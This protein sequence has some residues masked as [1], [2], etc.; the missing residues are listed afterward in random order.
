M[1]EFRFLQDPAPDQLEEAVAWNH[2]ELFVL[3][4]QAA[5]GEVH[6]TEGLTWTFA[7]ENGDGMVAFPRLIEDHAGAQ[8]DVLME[9]YRARKPKR[10]VGCW[11]LDPP[12]PQDLGARLL[13]RGF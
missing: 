2:R 9:Y 7:G 13:A 11:S 8:L 1:P 5:R 12:Q 6:E 4:A 10:L 3:E